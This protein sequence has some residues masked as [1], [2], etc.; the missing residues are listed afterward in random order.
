MSMFH[1]WLF[2][3][4]DAIFVLLTIWNSVVAAS[5]PPDENSHFASG[6]SVVGGGR[7]QMVHS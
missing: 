3:P 6:V 7:L 1:S 4:P 2:K 5:D